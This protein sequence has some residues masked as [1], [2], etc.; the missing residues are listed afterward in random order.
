VAVAV[1]LDPVRQTGQFG[2]GEH[3]SPA[4]EVETQSARQNPLAR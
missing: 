3:F 4:F 2:I 1:G